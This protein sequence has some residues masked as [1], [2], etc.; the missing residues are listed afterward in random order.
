MKPDQ[1][2]ITT[3]VIDPPVDADFVTGWHQKLKASSHLHM[4]TQR[5]PTL[6]RHG[7]RGAG[8]NTVDTRQRAG[9]AGGAGGRSGP[10]VD[11]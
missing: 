11:V 5:G 7:R 2:D 8:R 1:L 4:Q 3:T 10:A 6:D 9:L